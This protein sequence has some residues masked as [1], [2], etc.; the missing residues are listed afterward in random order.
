MEGIPGRPARVNV[1][2][3]A[4]PGRRPVL[5]EDSPHPAVHLHHRLR[6]GESDI[7]LVDLLGPLCPRPGIS[8]LGSLCFYG[9]PFR[10]RNAALG[11]LSPP[12]CSCPASLQSE[13]TV[14]A[15]TL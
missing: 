12:S 14:L 11:V 4:R 8:P 5:L 15:A 7:Q 2:A 6:T 13:W 10:G 3:A 9:P 1:C